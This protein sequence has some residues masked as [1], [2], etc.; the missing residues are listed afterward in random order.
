[1]G[2]ADETRYTFPRGLRLVKREDFQRIFEGGSWMNA[3]CLSAR[4]VTN[5]LGRPRLGF[6]TPRKL[7]S[8]PPRNRVARVMRE[9]YRLNQHLLSAGVD[10]VFM[11]KRSWTDYRLAVAEP[12]MQALLRRIEERYGD[13]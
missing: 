4:L 9:A 1:M 5:D 12:S 6:V 13:R 2:Q 10:V 7:G 3:D 11:P 8:H